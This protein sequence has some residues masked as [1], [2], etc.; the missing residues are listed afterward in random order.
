MSLSLN[1]SKTMHEDIHTDP[2]LMAIH[3]CVSETT[4]AIPRTCG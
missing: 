2:S 1:E 4:S 3:N